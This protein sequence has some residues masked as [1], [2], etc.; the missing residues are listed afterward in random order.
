MSCAGSRRTAPCSAVTPEISEAGHA[1]VRSRRMARCR[2]S[3]SRSGATLKL[4]P[5]NETHRRN[6]T[7]S[8]AI[9]A[10]A[11]GL[12]AGAERP[13]HRADPVA[14]GR[15]TRAP[16]AESVVMSHSSRLFDEP[17]DILALARKIEHDIGDALARAMIGELARPRPVGK[18][19]KTI[20]SQ[21]VIR[22]STGAGG[23]KRRMLQEPDKIARP[24]PS[25]IS[26]TDMGVHRGDG[27]RDSRPVPDADSPSQ[28]SRGNV[29]ASWSLKV[30]L[31]MSG[32]VVR[33]VRALKCVAMI[34]I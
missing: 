31:L 23:I 8:A 1:S 32:T 11:G 6:R 20:R 7:P 28:R 13:I 27:F 5:W 24:R 15:S 30:A 21:Q 16:N 22:A 12:T 9:L 4:I 18:D 17:A 2:K 19:R 3:G 25:R 10:C 33:S 26:R 14:C 29:L 34:G